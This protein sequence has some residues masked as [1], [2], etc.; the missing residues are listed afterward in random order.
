MVLQVLWLLK[1]TAIVMTLTI[2]GCVSPASRFHHH[3][4]RQGLDRYTDGS[5]V[6]YQRGP[7]LDGQPIH[8]YF[9]GDGMPSLGRGRIATDPTSRNMLILDLMA[10]DPNSTVLI[11]RPCYYRADSECDESLW[12]N[13]RYSPAVVDPMTDAINALIARYPNSP[14][15]LIGYSGGGTLAMLA[16][17]AISRLDTLVT[18]AANL[19]TAAWTTRHAYTPLLGSLNPADRSPLRPG[20]KQIHFIGD[21]DSNVPAEIMQH[22]VQ[23]Q[24][25]AILEIVADFDHSCCWV[26]S[27][28]E[29]VAWIESLEHVETH[30][31]C[32]PR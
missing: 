22:V 10:A 11:G 2:F 27:W 21:K 31:R 26:N 5:L 14:V 25:M 24:P 15:M 20:I 17:P 12:T 13:R 18:I 9:D 32:A 6:I 3:A 28:R 30:G 7:L 1:I 23:L 29:S 4:Q 16:A 19:D 8:I